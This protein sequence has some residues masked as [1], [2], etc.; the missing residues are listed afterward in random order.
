MRGIIASNA[1]A[2]NGVVALWS[3]YMADNRFE[4]MEIS[5]GPEA[6]VQNPNGE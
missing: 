1:F 4:S 3:R 6:V 2:S 5:F